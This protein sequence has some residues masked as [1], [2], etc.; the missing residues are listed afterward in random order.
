MLEPAG[1]SGTTTHIVYS[2]T[3][4]LQQTAAKQR[5]VVAA[6]AANREM[7]LSSFYFSSQSVGP[8]LPDPDSANPVPRLQ[9]SSLA[10]PFADAS[11]FVVVCVLQASVIIYD[12]VPNTIAQK[13]EKKAAVIPEKRR[14]FTTGARQGKRSGYVYL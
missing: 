7:R 14:L 9:R 13:K 4:A 12:R 10:R 3:P 11:G 5:A 1:V 6:A 2:R 8:T